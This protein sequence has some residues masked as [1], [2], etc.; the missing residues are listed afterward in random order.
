MWAVLCFK[1]R[2][3]ILH[4]TE[5]IWEST[6]HNKTRII[7]NKKHTTTQK[8]KTTNKKCARVLCIFVFCFL[9]A[10]FSPEIRGPQICTEKTQTLCV[11][12]LWISFCV[13]LCVCFRFHFFLAPSIF[14]KGQC[15]FGISDPSLQ[16]TTS[17]NINK[18]QRCKPFWR[19]SLSLNLRGERHR[20]IPGDPCFLCCLFFIL[21]F[22]TF[23]S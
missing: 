3:I 23:F 22:R 15:W 12:V 11:R 10:L 1:R 16:R 4:F 2:R 7:K 5:N 6:Q 13:S 8:R 14:V 19:I 21:C 20:Q 9:F 18:T 17:T